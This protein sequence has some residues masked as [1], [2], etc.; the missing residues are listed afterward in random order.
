MK[1]F[2]PHTVAG[3]LAAGVLLAGCGGSSPNG[4]STQS[5]TASSAKNFQQ[6]F[7][8]F[9]SCMRSHGVTDYPDPQFTGS[10]GVRISP[11]QANPN[12]PAFK[13]AQADCHQ[14]L[15][16]GGEPVGIG[17]TQAKAQEVKFADCIRAH[18]VPNFPDPSH[19]GAFDLPPGLNPQAPQFSQAMHACKRVQP[20][21]LSVNQSSAG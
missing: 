2:T 11:G 20:S 21:S 5:A 12:T 7:V 18:G 15:P 19:D 1:H 17:G 16:N 13:S 10:G 6:K 9:A 3:L 8:A 14:L 4:S